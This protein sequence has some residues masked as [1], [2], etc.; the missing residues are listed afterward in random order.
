MVSGGF[1]ITVFVLNTPAS[2]HW[3][4][5]CSLF[6]YH[7]KVVDA[8]IPEKKSKRGSRFGFVRY[9]NYSD[10][11]RAISRL[12]GFV[13]LGSRIWV[14]VVRAFK[15]RNPSFLKESSQKGLENVKRGKEVEEQL[16][17]VQTPNMLDRRVAEVVQGHVEDEQLW[18]LQKCLVGE[19]A[20]FCELKSLVDKVA[21]IGLGE[22]GVKRIQGNYFLI[23]IQDKELFEI[24]KQREWSYWKEFFIKIKPWSERLVFSE[25]VPWIEVFGVP[26]NCWNYETF[27]R[28]A[29]KWGTLVSMGANNFEKVEML[30]SISQVK[31]IDEMV[32]LEV[33]DVS[34]LVSVRELGWSED[35]KN[36]VSKKVW[37]RRR[38]EIPET[39]GRSI[40]QEIE[41][42]FLSTI[43][44]RRKKKQFNKRIRS[45]RVIQDGCCLP[46]KFKEEIG[47]GERIRAVLCQG[48]K[49]K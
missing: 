23:E 8:F 3:K 19:V 36:I 33:G 40:R 29:G 39:E 6:S 38:V 5:L 20:S 34:F 11:Y 10:A 26:M 27:K 43:R 16:E 4:G 31:K 44:S 18:K 48:E 46:K 15:Q 12:N 21:R 41:E 2:M 22:I 28:I 45:M 24:L 47:P 42:E 7:G 35:H 30:I 49:T 9:T 32:F 13:I 14:K 1:Q 25:R 37:S 17:D